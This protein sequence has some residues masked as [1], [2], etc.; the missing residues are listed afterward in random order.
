MPDA[1]AAAVLFN[2]A[3]ATRQHLAGAS[4][5][6][7]DTAPQPAIAAAAAAPVAASEIIPMQTSHGLGL[8]SKHMQQLQQQTPPGFEAAQRDAISNGVYVEPYDDNED[9]GRVQEDYLYLEE[10]PRPMLF[11]QDKADYAYSAD[12]A[13]ESA[14]LPPQLPE[15]APSS[16]SSSSSSSSNGAILYSEP[17]MLTLQGDVMISS[18]MPVSSVLLQ[19]S[20]TQPLIELATDVARGVWQVFGST[21]AAPSSMQQLQLPRPF[22]I[23]EMEVTVES[24]SSSS[25]DLRSTLDASES[26]S[27]STTSSSSSSSDAN[28]DAL[29]ISVTVESSRP[30]P[31]LSTFLQAVALRRKPAVVQETLDAT[32]IAA[33]VLKALGRRGAADEQQQQQQLVEPAVQQQQV[34]DMIAGLQATVSAQSARVSF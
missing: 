22:R 28:A 30:R 5:A 6:D 14:L 11:V 26:Y 17:G 7:A 23:Q 12:A 31:L 9:L 16:S 20:I 19:Q 27:S 10:P 29:E 34:Q 33:A 25:S 21:E 13:A 4:D 15:D 2:T 8:P 18:R 1:A 24:S 32:A 3:E